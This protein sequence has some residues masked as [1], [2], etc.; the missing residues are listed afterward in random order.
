MNEDM[1]IIYMAVSHLLWLPSEAKSKIAR[2]DARAVCL[3]ASCS[4]SSITELYDSSYKYLWYVFVI[5]WRSHTA[6][7]WHCIASLTLG[8]STL[9]MSSP[10]TLQDCCP[11][12]RSQHGTVMASDGSPPKS[13]FAASS[14]SYY[15]SFIN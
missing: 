4:V 1:N 9:L 14:I 2:W 12:L 5:Q 10:A 7:S 11:A 15:F 8:C 13:G 6:A 3:L